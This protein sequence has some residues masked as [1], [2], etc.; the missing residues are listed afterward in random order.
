M[1]THLRLGTHN[2]YYRPPQS[3]GKAK[4]ISREDRTS[5]LQYTLRNSRHPNFYNE[6]TAYTTGSLPRHTYGRGHLEGSCVGRNEGLLETEKEKRKRK[7]KRLRKR[8][9]SRTMGGAINEDG[10]YLSDSEEDEEEEKKVWKPSAPSSAQSGTIH[11]SKNK[12]SK[13]GGNSD[14]GGLEATIQSLNRDGLDWSKKSKY[15]KK[16]HKNF[17]EWLGELALVKHEAQVTA[18]DA[19]FCF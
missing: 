10:Y 1:I 14:L 12:E 8:H 13:T 9:Q 5:L 19:L 6:K 7:D 15:G 16:S 4:N 11:P 18:E 2:P 17:D 3:G